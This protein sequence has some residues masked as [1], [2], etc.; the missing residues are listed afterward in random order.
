MCAFALYYKQRRDSDGNQ[1]YHPRTSPMS[2]SSRAAQYRRL[3]TTPAFWLTPPA[4]RSAQGGR[5]GLH[6]VRLPAPVPAGKRSGPGGRPNKCAGRGGSPAWRQAGDRHDDHLLFKQFPLFFHDAGPLPVRDPPPALLH[7]PSTRISPE[8]A[9]PA[10]LPS[11]F[12]PERTAGIICFE[13][14]DYEYAQMLCEQGIPILFAD[15]R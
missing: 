9:A 11:A 15:S 13:E 4:K 3:S 8:G 5:N 14:F 12:D 10:R 7:D 6:A 2:C 1:S